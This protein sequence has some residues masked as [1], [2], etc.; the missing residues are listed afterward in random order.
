MEI[1]RCNNELRVIIFFC[2][3]LCYTLYNELQIVHAKYVNIAQFG[4]ISFF[5]TLFL[6]M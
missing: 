5:K 2:C 6:S 4:K 1:F 3:E